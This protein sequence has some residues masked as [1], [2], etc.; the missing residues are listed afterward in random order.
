MA[1]LVI[2]GFSTIVLFIAMAI[3]VNLTLVVR[4]PHTLS[5][6][7]RARTSRSTAPSRCAS[8]AMNSAWRCWR[9]SA[10]AQ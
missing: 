3:F 5:S 10:D 7:P 8:R 1:G 9:S 6:S 4:N 2:W